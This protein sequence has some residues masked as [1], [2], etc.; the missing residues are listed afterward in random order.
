MTRNVVVALAV[1]FMVSLAANACTTVYCHRA[2]AHRALVLRRPAVEVFRF[3]Q[4][5][6][7]GIRPRQWVAVH[8][9]H[10]AYTDVPGDPHSPVLLGWLT[11]QRS[12]VALYR[13]EAANPATLAKYARDLPRDRLDRWLYDRAIPGLALGTGLLVVMLGPLVGLLAAFVHMNLYLAGSAAVNA[14]G[15]HFGRRP[16]P[17]GAGNLHWLAVFTAGEGYHNNHHGAPTSA[18]LSRHWYEP[19]LG[20]WIIRALVIVRL[21]SLRAMTSGRVA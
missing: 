11:V 3:V 1:G 16:Y 15:H 6:T 17:N 4:W 7:T 21:A 14:I 8:R 19:D 18:R 10:H 20:W 9:K 5:I 12:N 2:L 13:R